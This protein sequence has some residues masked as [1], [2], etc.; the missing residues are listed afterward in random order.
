VHASAG[1]W[2]PPPGALRPAAQSWLPCSLGPT[3]VQ[4]VLD[5][6]AQD[7]H[8]PPTAWLKLLVI[9]VTDG[10]VSGLLGGVHTEGKPVGTTIQSTLQRCPCM[11]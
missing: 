10:G 2:V 5:L 3:N 7:H 1:Y 9:Q 4:L 8:L 6:T 11:L